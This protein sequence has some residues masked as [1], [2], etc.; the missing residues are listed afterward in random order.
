[1]SRKASALGKVDD[2]ALRV[3]RAALDQ[4]RAKG[5]LG[6]RGVKYD[7]YRGT[8]IETTVAGILRGGELMERLGVGERGE[9]ILKATCFYV[10]GGGQIS[11]TGRIVGDEWEF[12]V[13][14]T[15]QPIPGL[16]VH[17]GE[18]SRGFAH[19]G[20]AVSAE[21]DATRR[22]DIMRNHTATH[23]LHAELRAVLGEH[24]QQAGSLA[25]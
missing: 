21:V 8:E 13:D 2:A 14:D 12:R 1:L 15:R 20:N 24:V 23:L 4:L 19:S 10:E 11:D 17:I 3:Y 6:E 18:M 7:P 5:A 16:I 25:F 22:L 9:I